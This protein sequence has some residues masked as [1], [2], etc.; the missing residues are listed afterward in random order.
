MKIHFLASVLLL[1]ASCSHDNACPDCDEVA[2]Y[3]NNVEPGSFVNLGC[4]CERP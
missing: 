3:P 1:L 4:C 2:P